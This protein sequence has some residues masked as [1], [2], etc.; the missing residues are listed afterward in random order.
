[1]KKN[2]SLGLSILL[3]LLYI[4]GGI[5]HIF[6]KQFA[7]LDMTMGILTLLTL[8]IAFVYSIVSFRKNR[9]KRN[10]IALI[11]NSSVF[12]LIILDM[13]LSNILK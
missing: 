9:I 4:G 1:M 8:V 10:T 11:I 6:I 12:L 13:T 3:L 5:V 2:L 7:V